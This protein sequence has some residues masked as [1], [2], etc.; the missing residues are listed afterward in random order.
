LLVVVILVL[1][2]DLPQ[3]A[4]VPDEGA[5]QEPAAVSPDPSFGNRVHAERLHFAQHG[6]DPGIGKDRVECGRE[7]SSHGRGS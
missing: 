5:I 1:A 6:P 7:G 4:L 2:Q 3:M